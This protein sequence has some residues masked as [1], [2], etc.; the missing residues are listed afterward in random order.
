MLALV[1]ADCCAGAAV[2]VTVAAAVV[3][4]CCGALTAGADGAEGVDGADGME[5]APWAV[6]AG[7][8][9]AK[10][11][12]GA[13]PSASAPKSTKIEH[14]DGDLALTST[15]VGDL[16]IFKRAAPKKVALCDLLLLAKPKAPAVARSR[17]GVPAGAGAGGSETP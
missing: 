3:A 2:W 6:T 11:T 13:T 17:R 4:C 16:R 1:V 12:L 10:P 8:P 5:G 9:A 15:H 14:L 7:G